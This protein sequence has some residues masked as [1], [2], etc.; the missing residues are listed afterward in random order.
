MVLD[1]LTVWL[2]VDRFIGGG[3]CSK[4]LRSPFRGLAPPIRVQ[5]EGAVVDG[6]NSKLGVEIATITGRV[7]PIR[8]SRNVELSLSTGGN[9]MVG[10]NRLDEG[11]KV[12]DPSGHHLGVTNCGARKVTDTVSAAAGLVTELPGHDGGRVLVPGHEGL[13]VVLVRVDNFGNMVELWN[14]LVSGGI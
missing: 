14:G 10:V 7:S 1:P 3:G 11:G 2:L 9:Q 12:L 5:M 8:V 6:V 4:D 13:D